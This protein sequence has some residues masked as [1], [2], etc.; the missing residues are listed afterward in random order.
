[1]RSSDLL[2]ALAR[3]RL[4]TIDAAHKLLAPDETRKEVERAFAVEKRRG[5]IVAHQIRGLRAHYYQLSLK[6]AR[7]LGLPDRRAE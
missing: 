6:A 7:E 3:Y 1:L 4:L 5:N 2:P